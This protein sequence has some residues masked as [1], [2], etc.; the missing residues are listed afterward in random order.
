MLF[1]EIV[2][3]LELK[4]RPVM[5]SDKFRNYLHKKYN[6]EG[7]REDVSDLRAKIINYQ[8]DVYGVTI[9][10]KVV[11]KSKEEI[12]RINHVRSNRK[13]KRKQKYEKCNN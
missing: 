8:L 13:Y 9:S 3:F 10:D 4:D 11:Y 2:I 1:K 12:Y 7:T 6:F 5:G